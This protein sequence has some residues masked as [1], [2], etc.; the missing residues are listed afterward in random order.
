MLNFG[1]K[2]DKGDSGNGVLTSK[3]ARK[4]AVN[5][6]RNFHAYNCPAWEWS[7]F[8][9]IRMSWAICTGAWRRHSLTPGLEK[10]SYIHRY[11]IN[12]NKKPNHS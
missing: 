1:E 7:G 11:I 6:C 4:C 8:L 2:P 5:H 12:Q 9:K 3:T 10:S